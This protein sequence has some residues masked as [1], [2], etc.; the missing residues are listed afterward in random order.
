MA[1][2]RPRIAAL[3]EATYAVIC[4]HFLLC[5]VPASHSACFL[6]RFPKL[7]HFVTNAIGAV[8]AEGIFTRVEIGSR[9]IVAGCLG[10]VRSGSSSC[11]SL[12][13]VEIAFGDIA[14]PLVTLGPVVVF[15]IFQVPV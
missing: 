10:A 2:T 14:R 6:A 3:G 8:E 5:T 13:F 1:C 12:L 15:S 11:R 9:L 4:A 7:L